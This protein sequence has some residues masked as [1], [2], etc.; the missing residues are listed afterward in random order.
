MLTLI[1]TGRCSPRPV[2]VI[3]FE[4]SDYWTSWKSYIK[5]QL[6]DRG[7]ISEEDIDLIKEVKN[8]DEIIHILK[9]FYSVYHSI[10]Y[11]NENSCI[12][13]N[14]SLSEKKLSSIN[15]RFSHLLKSGKYKIMSADA[16]PSEKKIYPDKPRLVFNFNRSN[17]GG[18]CQLINFINEPD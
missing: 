15:D 9:T 2:I 13:L 1:Q 5:T 4:D 8:I 14:T 3:N 16:I 17:Y 10:R 18:L 7:Y 11:L 12:R 6:L